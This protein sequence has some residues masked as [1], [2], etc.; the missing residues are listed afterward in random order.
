MAPHVLITGG[1]GFVGGNLCVGLAGRHP[2]WSI[3]ALDNLARRGSELNL[4]R[5]R[6]AGVRFR[7]GDVRCREDVLG[8]DRVDAVVEC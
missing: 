4:P 6:R 5:L 3:T 1:S 7:H 8:L 2:D